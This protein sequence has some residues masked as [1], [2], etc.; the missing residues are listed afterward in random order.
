MWFPRGLEAQ[1]RPQLIC[2]V[3]SAQCQQCRASRRRQCSDPKPGL[4][5]GLRLRLVPFDWH[6]K[7]GEKPTDKCC[8]PGSCELQSWSVAGQR[9]GIEALVPEEE[10]EK[11]AAFPWLATSNSWHWE[12]RVFAGQQWDCL[13]KLQ[14]FSHRDFHE[15]ACQGSP[16]QPQ[17]KTCV[18]EIVWPQSSS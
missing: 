13:M 5:L 10:K 3:P 15:R 14:G 12:G 11:L 8:A 18:A 9:G 7:L 4:R 17:R 6:Q 2:P 1:S 16:H